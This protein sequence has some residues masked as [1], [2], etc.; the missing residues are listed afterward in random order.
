LYVYITSV[1]ETIIAVQLMPKF[2]HLLP[3]M[4]DIKSP[5]YPQDVRLTL[6]REK[7]LLWWDV[8]EVITDPWKTKCSFDSEALNLITVSERAG[9]Q[10]KSFNLISKLLIGQFVD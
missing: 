5:T 3:D 7:Q 6:R 8:S 10:S 4:V 9:A 2:I 1:Q